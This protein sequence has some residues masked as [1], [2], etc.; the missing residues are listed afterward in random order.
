MSIKK[1]SDKKRIGSFGAMLQNVFH[2]KEQQK[3]EQLDNLREQAIK[4]E[5]E[6]QSELYQHAFDEIKNDF[7]KWKLSSK[8]DAVP[9]ENKFRR[10]HNHQLT[11]DESNE[12]ELFIGFDFGS[13]TTKVV[14]GDH[15][16]K[17]A[18]YPI[19]FD[20]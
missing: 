2:E 4:K 8:N 3:I 20:E 17:D 18:K 11:D 19:K 10:F 9:A 14:I 12:T 15:N 1:H 5:I 13:S 16:R 7:E 6:E